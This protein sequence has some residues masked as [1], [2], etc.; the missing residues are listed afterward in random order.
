[1]Y[2]L[3]P[4]RR[5]EPVMVAAAQMTVMWSLTDLIGDYFHI[6][7]GTHH[8]FH[9][10][11]FDTKNLHVFSVYGKT[12]R[13]V[14]WVGHRVCGQCKG[15]GMDCN[16]AFKCQGE[17]NGFIPHIDLCPSREVMFLYTGDLQPQT[18]HPLLHPHQPVRMR[19]YY[20][21]KP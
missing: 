19:A 6:L 11:F 8:F 21:S 16:K 10:L 9:Y 14:V 1:M 15:C 5:E 2:F 12:P 13:G 7:I 17:L 20:M 3:F 18:S 4:C